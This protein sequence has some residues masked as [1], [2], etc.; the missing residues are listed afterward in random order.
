VIKLTVSLFGA[1]P[2]LRVALIGSIIWC[3]AITLSVWFNSR[4]MAWGVEAQ[5]LEV[6]LIMAIGALLGFVP[7]VAAANLIA[8]HRRQSQLMAALLIGLTL[9]TIGATA[10]VY[11]LQYRAYYAI[12]HDHAGSHDWYWQQF[13][14]TAS[15]FYQFAVLGTRLY[16]PWGPALLIGAAYVL[17]TKRL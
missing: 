6:L 11:L 9:A 1:L 13:F 14:T 8:A 10:F 16:L 5:R 15:A 17:S 3:A 12:W 7:G 2:S 4:F